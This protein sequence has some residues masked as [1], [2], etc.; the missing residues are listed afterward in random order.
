MQ[1]QQDQRR[2]GTRRRAI[3]LAAV[4]PLLA[5]ACGGGDDGTDEGPGTTGGSSSGAASSG[6]P[7]GTLNLLLI[8]DFEHLDPQRTYVASALEFDARY[9]TRT[10]VAYDSKPGAAGSKIVPDLAT[11][12][13][14]PS[15]GAKTWTFRLKEGVKF[16]DG[17]PVRCADLKY[18]VSRTFSSQITDGPVY[19]LQYLNVQRDKEGA[20]V[21]KG[22]YVGGSNGG[23]DQAVQCPDDRTIVFNLARAISDFNYTVSLPA[24][25]PV[26]KAR[27]TGT[28]YDRSVF[29]SGPYRI[30]S[31]VPDK[32][33]TLVRNEHWDAKTDPIRKAYPDSVVATFG[34]DANI[35]DSRLMADSPS[36]QTA[37]ML[38]STVQS[39][40]IT[41]VLG[42]PQLTSRAVTGFDSYLRYLAINTAKV[43]DLKVRQAVIYA[44]NKETYRGSRGGAPAG[45]YAKSVLL[46]TLSGHVDFD[47]YP[48][49]P[50]GDPVKAD[51]LLRESGVSLPVQMK[52]DYANTPQNARSAASFREALQRA[53]FRVS[54]N[55]IN[56]DSYYAT[57]GR[58]SVQNELSLAS[59]GPDWP[60]AS[61]VIPPLFDGRQIAPEGNQNYSQLNDPEVNALLVKAGTTT[62]A[63]ALA[64]TWGELDRKIMAQAAIVP[65]I[66]SKTSQ[67]H[68]SK[69]KGAFQ[70][71]FYGLIDLAT[72]SVR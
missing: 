24:F 39:Q 64:T 63:A 22:P 61:S 70:H 34:L 57:I 16:E 10:L 28:R 42:S 37:V 68:G 9:L 14:T 49:P 5:G 60:S 38:D 3:A 55:P 21:Y 59:W 67:M 25:A 71:S 29:S 72:L 52:L 1:G 66:F 11:D 51:Q 36:D 53:Q 19:A 17:S 62:D 6:K 46:P 20:P 27:D 8:S 69:V 12:L 58:T 26:P 41:R 13:G 2:R 50:Q 44:L 4:L 54:L 15:N 35:I 40:N 43:K 65:L 7:G 23:F 47:P 48:A 30:D 32:A 33:I 31:Y 18:G 45:D 56:P